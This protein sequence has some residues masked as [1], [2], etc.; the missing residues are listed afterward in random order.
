LIAPPVEAPRVLVVGDLML[1]HYL[2]GA[3][4][5]ISPEAPV[6]VVDVAREEQR[7]GGAGNV[8]GNLVSLGAQAA[9]VAV[10]G[11][12]AAGER[13]Q[14]MLAERGVATG[15]IVVDPARRT[16][17]KTRV[18]VG[19]QQVVRFD[20]E[21]R[22]AVDGEIEARLLDAVRQSPIAPQVILL[23]D[24]AKGVF[25]PS[26]TQA[27]IREARA[28][29]IPVLVDPKGRDY[30][31]Y[32]G[33]TLVTPNRREAALLTGMPI[34]TEEALQTAG[35][36][37]RRELNLDYALIT[38][39]EHG[40]A[41]FGE[42]MT[43]IPAEAREVFDVTGAG[44]TVL[45]TLGFGV[46][47]GLPLEKA[48]R[49]A[50]RAAAVAVS[51]VGNATVRLEQIAAPPAEPS[52]GSKVVSRQELRPVLERL[53]AAGK[54]IVFTNGCFDLLH[55]GHVEYLQ[56]S[57]ECG[58]VLV[59]GLNADESVRRLKGPQRPVMGE[60]DRARILAALAAVDY[61]V[62]FEEDTPRSLIETLRPHVLTK[63]ADYAGK[64]V[65]GADLV[66]EVRL[67]ALCEGRST[68]GTIGRIR[69][70]A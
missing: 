20:R 43:R 61:V 12:D 6:P 62:I 23:S 44:D 36:T 55:R 60:E 16:T 42:R 21:S 18:V 8:A 35:Q 47:A 26:L 68:S 59:V 45:A 10:V 29:S 66:E 19:G 69:V 30:Q 54:R 9:A 70:A 38:L 24:Y 48:A 40:M 17:C 57:R 53:K 34:D 37:L 67:I 3:S 39:S 64:E 11:G 52:R 2:Y 63:G 14:T 65:A 4:D 41:L 32:R 33:A 15:G 7:L 27:V 5:R 22:A 49:L 50:N 13:L 56:A 31:K 1:D 58:D 28:R 46:A 25:T 51:R